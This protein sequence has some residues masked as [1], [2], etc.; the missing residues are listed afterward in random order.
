MGKSFDIS[1]KEFSYITD[2]DFLIAKFSITKKIVGL[3][4]DAERELQ[5]VV[6]NH[7]FPFN[8]RWG[9]RSGKISK[10]ENYRNLPYVVLDF[11]RHF[12]SHEVFAFRS[13][14]WWGNFFSCTLHL[15]G[16]WLEQ[17]R[18]GIFK[19]LQEAPGDVFVCVNHSPWEYHYG[20]ENYR[21]AKDFTP[22]ELEQ[23]ILKK[24]FIKLSRKTDLENWRHMPLFCKE[25]FEMFVRLFDA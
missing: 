11:P 24:P 7:T 14:F 5:L 9:Y 16:E 22:D 18:H 12:S 10:G 15:M 8:D 13:M 23:T 20:E 3:F 17:F 1:D 19:K 2:T 21:P 25:T 4:A 6:N